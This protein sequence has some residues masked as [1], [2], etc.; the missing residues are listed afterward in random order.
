M[1]AQTRPLRKTGLTLLVFLPLCGSHVGLSGDPYAGSEG[2]ESA[3][4]SLA[5]LG[6]VLG[7]AGRYS[8]AAEAF[9][10]ALSIRQE[11]LGPLDPRVAEC[12]N[13]LAIIHIARGNYVDAEPLCRRALDIYDQMS[14]A[15][16]PEVAR[17]LRTMGHLRAEK[18]GDYGEAVQ[19]Y[20]RA[21]ATQERSLGTEHREVAATLNLLSAAYARQ[22]RLAEAEE[23]S[24]RALAISRETLGPAHPDVAASLYA[25]AIVEWTKGDLLEAE[26]LCLEAVAIGE[27]SLGSEHPLVA[28]ML[29]GLGSLGLHQGKYQEAEVLYRR[30]AAVYAKALGSG[31][32]VSAK[33]IH[34]L[35]V[36]YT[37]QGRC[38]EAEPLFRQVLQIRERTLGPGHPQVASCL[39][40]MSNLY[41][42]ESEF[43]VADSLASRALAI[44]EDT[45]GPRC[46]EVAV[47]LGNLA[48]I[49]SEGWHRYA[50]SERLL[51]RA[52]KIETDLSGSENA[53]T[54]NIVA[55]LAEMSR[56]QGKSAEAESRYESAISA[57]EKALGPYHP[58]VYECL[59][60]L[61]TCCLE[62]GDW[63]S[64]ERHL[65]A[66]ADVF[67]TARLRAGA[68]LARTTFRESPYGRL[69]ALRLQMGDGDR[70]W[71]ATER[72]LGRALA[73]LLIACDRRGLDPSESAREDSLIRSLGELESRV[74]AL[75]DAQSVDTTMGT[76]EKLE[77]V[78]GQLLN[79]EASWTIFRQEMAEKHPINEGQAFPL[80]RVQAALAE[81]TALVGWV[82][83]DVESKDVEG[84]DATLWAYVVGRSGPVTWVRV[85]Q[86]SRGV[87]G[88]SV[89]EAIH[90]LRQSLAFA[91]SW[92][93]RVTD[94]D[95]VGP[96]AE[97]VW[98]RLFAGLGP[99]LTGIRSL[100]AVASGPILGVPLEALADSNG[101]YLGNQYSVSY[102]PSA[103]VHTWLRE[104]SGQSRPASKRR[105]LLVGDPPFTED[106]LAGMKAAGDTLGLHTTLSGSAPDAAMVRSALAG[107]EDA[108][109]KLPRLPWTREEVRAA[110]AV[111]PGAVTLLG[112][113]AS[114][115]ELLRLAQS[116][117]LRNFDV[118]HLATHA[119]VDDEMP[120]RSALVFS[121]VGLPDPL[122][123]AMAGVRIYDGLVSAKEIIREWPLS[124]D[125][126]T[127]S[128][129]QTGLGMEVP[130]EGYV[131]LAQAFL[132]A[133]ARSLLVSLW[134]VEDE[135]T[136]LLMRRFYE[137]LTGA[138]TDDRLGHH[139]ESMPKAEALREAKMWLREYVDEE[140]QRR[141]QHP[142]Y[143]SGFILI[144][145][146]M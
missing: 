3:A 71:I 139:R 24:R 131:G 2:R 115:L 92:Q 74:A 73:D 142:V 122:G 61:A 140:G 88:D 10:R 86:K 1:F 33:P 34:N 89:T 16:R 43:Q 119:F 53:D 75:E 125:L 63:V 44:Y 58:L 4:D 108:L 114:E 144:G 25:L 55:Q 129:C 41:R 110:A 50:D 13:E 23:A 77:E 56:L 31:N 60:G 18:A 117:E 104:E 97:I 69:A 84:R 37:Q 80:E 45:R 90:K 76:A 107:S 39:T 48:A 106:H 123:A 32:A 5:S 109:A 14:D 98:Q 29:T 11:D 103:T 26:R 20:E 15:Y 49:R 134:R 9:E 83:G 59:D 42:R 146:P 145:S 124:A 30:A 87:Q 120:E 62:R 133:G 130:G 113:D 138:F 118:I 64:A 81:G 38:S 8:E 66:A 143:W 101:T 93:E 111:L 47:A 121:Q 36:L 28:G 100:V 91:A 78:R 46:H 96:A 99:H 136:A 54:P 137:N 57:A 35:A 65:T 116:K 127:L 27:K 128:G 52:L 94:L 141:F 126:V 51:E 135:A 112:P 72:A 19:L 102:V 105:S 6:I 79:V 67:E 22:G 85:G 21:L 17:A 40:N 7:E 68:G 82:S 95:A 12:L 132:Q 70:A